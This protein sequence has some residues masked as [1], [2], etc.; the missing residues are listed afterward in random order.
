MG[1]LA[2]VTALR[3]GKLLFLLVWTGEKEGDWLL[4]YFPFLLNSV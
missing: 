3:S 4:K 2:A 1:C